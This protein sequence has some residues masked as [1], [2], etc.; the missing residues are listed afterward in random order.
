MEDC[1]LNDEPIVLIRGRN[2]I[3]YGIEGNEVSTKKCNQCQAD[4]NA[5]N[6]DTETDDAELD[7]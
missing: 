6:N 2:K 5:E 3:F 7:I 1:P 4:Y